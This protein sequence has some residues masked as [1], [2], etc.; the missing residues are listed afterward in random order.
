MLAKQITLEEYIEIRKEH[1]E[2][3]HQSSKGW[4]TLADI[5][6]GYRQWHYKAKDLDKAVG[7]NN[8]Y[9]SQNTFYKPQRRIEN[10]KELKHLYIDIDCYN[11][12]YSKE[13]VIYILEKDYF[14]RKIPMSN[15]IIDS[16]RG[17][18]LVWNIKAV[19]KMAL[20][21]WK[22]IE[23]YLY[24]QLK[25]FGADPRATDPTRILRVA[26]TVNTKSNTVVNILE[27]Y[28][29][30]YTLKE[31]Q[32]EYLPEIEPK[33]VKSKGRP[34][35]V[36]S[37]FNKYSLHHARLE[38]L[39]K[40]CEIRNYDVVGFR[41][42]ILF[43]YRYWTC[44]FVSDTREALRMTLELNQMFRQALPSR[45]VE[46]A[47]ESAEKAYLSK[48]KEYNYK[49]TTLIE[50]L[51]ISQEEQ[52]QLKTIIGIK[53]KNKRNR[54]NRNKYKR[55]TGKAKRRNSEGLTKREHEKQEKIKKVKELKE[56]GLNNSQIAKK[57]GITRV[58]V[59]NIINNRV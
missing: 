18:Y 9:I 3:L 7:D 48:D 4:I 8:Y 20:P 15:L 33:K 6:D 41:E 10:L 42:T 22:A 12:R 52:E 57:L 37:L 54:D 58:Y 56:K 24:M 21:L 28:D 59:S 27:R 11:T 14:N 26:G 39:V 44:C 47:T 45:E 34:K 25:E 35:R 32:K 53:E 38:D 2:I 17:L 13:D 50:L 5:N 51:D 43:L 16:G 19:P 55:E 36:V 46:K 1:T 40:I 30:E 29:Y 31:I 49:N 23:N